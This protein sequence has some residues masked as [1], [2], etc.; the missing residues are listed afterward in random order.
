M[1]LSAWLTKLRLLVKYIPAWFPG[2]HFKRSAL[3]TNRYLAQMMNGPF[4]RTKENMVCTHRTSEQNF[5]L[6]RA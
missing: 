3:A 2:A 1:G 5:G 6:M 4:E